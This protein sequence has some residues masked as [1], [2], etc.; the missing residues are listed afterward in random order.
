V[1][2]VPPGNKGVDPSGQS[3]LYLGM[4]VFVYI[5]RS[6][7]DGTYYIG[8]TQDIESRLKHHNRVGTQYTKQK[9]PWELVYKEEQPDRS[10]AMKREYAIKK[11]GAKQFL[12]SVA[13]T[14]RSD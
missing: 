1:N 4:P 10:S 11:R 2:D 7:K 5:L 6:L 8:S 3:L 9:R 14:S 13:K 12:E